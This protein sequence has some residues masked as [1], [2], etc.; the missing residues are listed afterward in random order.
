[1][2][3]FSN[4]KVII[5][6]KVFSSYVSQKKG[7]EATECPLVTSSSSVASVVPTNPDSTGRWKVAMTEAGIHLRERER[8]IF[9][10][11]VII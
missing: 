9:I 7:I 4:F 8:E 6:F 11:F 2:V 10:H 1:M 3:F 5:Y